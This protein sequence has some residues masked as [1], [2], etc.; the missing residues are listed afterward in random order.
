MVEGRLALRR[1][2]D[3]VTARVAFFTDSFHEVNGVAL[4]SRE[5]V[6]FAHRRSIPLLSIHAGPR[7]AMYQEGSVTTLEFKRGLVQWK[8]EHDL[9]IDLMFPRFRKRI[10]E[11]LREFKPDLIH[12]T[13][14]GDAGILGA[15]AA[16]ELKAPLAASWHTN[17]H[18]FAS[19]RMTRALRPFPAALSSRL[20]SWAE[21]KILDRC[22]WFYGLAKVLFAPN[23]ELVDLLALRTRRPAFL[24]VRGID[25]E[26]FSPA[27]R[28][29]TGKTFVIGYVGRVSPEKNV[30]MLASVEQALLAA[31]LVDYRILV[32]GQG[33]ERDWLAQNLRSAEFPGVLRGEA[34]ANAYASMDVL[35][36]P[37]HTDTFGNV[38]LESMAS[39]VPAVVSSRGGPK[40]LI[41]HGVT[42]WIAE[43]AADFAAAVAEMYRN[44]EK[45]SWMGEQA[46][47]IAERYSWD[48][49]FEE[50][51]ARYGAAFPITGYHSGC[52]ANKTIG[53][54]TTARLRA[55]G[56]VHRQSA[57]APLRPS[58]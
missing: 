19:R 30:R 1:R 49:V 32:V 39:G 6:R 29:R 2:G 51:Y 55:V 16:W 5:F 47:R 40:F 4:T 12:I 37:S 48:A 57:D 8:L 15:W 20:A 54:H 24:M 28:I 36:F 25:T 21:D 13:G 52:D 11:A 41:E 33:S 50:V 58:L 9:A 45:R 35:V 23:P 18:E 26:L 22:A 31:G 17:L 53:R 44:P 42:G 56:A 43:D 3:S 46:R 10:L 34:L 27:R 7:D 14:P 38:V